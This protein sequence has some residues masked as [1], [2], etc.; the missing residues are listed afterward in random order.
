MVRK[1][2]WVNGYRLFGRQQRVTNSLYPSPI[3][4]PRKRAANAFKA[5]GRIPR[6]RR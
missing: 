1:V 5:S 3:L 6:R 2:G 4:G